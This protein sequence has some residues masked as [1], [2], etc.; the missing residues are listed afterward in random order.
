MFHGLA[1]FSAEAVQIRPLI[2]VAFE[3]SP[4]GVSRVKLV[5]LSARVKLSAIATESV[6]H[7][8]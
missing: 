5:T 3:G 4:Q 7:I 8:N 2:G 6:L 1:S